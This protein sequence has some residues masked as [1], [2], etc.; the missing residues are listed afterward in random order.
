MKLLY[1]GTDDNSSLLYMCKWS[2]LEDIIIYY[3]REES[4]TDKIWTVKS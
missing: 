1:N 2:M 4:K 3:G